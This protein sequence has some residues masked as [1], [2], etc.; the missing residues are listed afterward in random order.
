[1]GLTPITGYSLAA[2]T[3]VLDSMGWS[4]YLLQHGTALQPLPQLL[5]T[6]AA[7]WAAATTDIVAAGEEGDVGGWTSVGCFI[8]AVGAHGRA[9]SMSV[10]SLLRSVVENRAPR[11]EVFRKRRHQQQQQQQASSAAATAAAAAADAGTDFTLQVT[12]G[13]SGP[14][15]LHVSTL[16]VFREAGGQCREVG[17]ALVTYRNQYVRDMGPTLELIEVKGRWR[18]MGVASRLMQVSCCWDEEAQPLPHPT[19]LKAFGMV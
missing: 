5:P 15:H 18:R 16:F 14:H 17:R 10:K 4:Y 12:T 19:H 13:G 9:P 6:S 11:E 8:R 2:A 3:D 7:A 1:M